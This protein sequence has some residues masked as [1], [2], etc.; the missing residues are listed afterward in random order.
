MK[1]CMMVI[2]ILQVAACIVSMNSNRRSIHT[3]KRYTTVRK[4]KIYSILDIQNHKW[5]W[6]GDSHPIF[7]P[8]GNPDGWRRE[9]SYSQPSS[10]EVHFPFPDNE[11]PIIGVSNRCTFERQD[12]EYKMRGIPESERKDCS[13]CKEFKRN[14]CSRTNRIRGCN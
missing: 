8:V 6:G 13:E 1:A 14:S 10:P 9:R 12:Y 3:L 5:L 7:G 4:S 11:S 2:I